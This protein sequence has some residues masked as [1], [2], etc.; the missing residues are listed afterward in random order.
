MIQNNFGRVLSGSIL[1]AGPVIECEVM[2]Q[3]RV[4]KDADQI[5]NRIGAI[6]TFIYADAPHIEDEATALLG[7]ATFKTFRRMR[8]S[9][10]CVL[11]NQ[12][13]V[14]IKPGSESDTT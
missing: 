6:D 14:D 1:I 11:K 7:L 3:G 5:N 2:C 4:D 13:Y 12:N 10:P 8:G 9:I